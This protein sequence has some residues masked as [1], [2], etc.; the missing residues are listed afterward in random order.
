[1]MEV[2]LLWKLKVLAENQGAS[3]LLLLLHFLNHERS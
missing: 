3:F 1:M 2:T